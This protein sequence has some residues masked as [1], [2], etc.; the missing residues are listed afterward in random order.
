MGG[1][2]SGERVRDE[3]EVSS[4]KRSKLTFPRA[5]FRPS[6]LQAHTQTTTQSHTRIYTPLMLRTASTPRWPPSRS[7]CVRSL[8]RTIVRE[9]ALSTEPAQ[10]EPTSSSSA[11][12]CMRSS[13]PYE[14][15]TS[16]CTDTITLLWYAAL[17]TRSVFAQRPGT[18][19]ANKVSSTSSSSPSSPSIQASSSSTSPTRQPPIRTEPEP[20][21]PAMAAWT[22]FGQWS[23]LEPDHSARASVTVVLTTCLS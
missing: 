4:T 5:G 11:G 8:G 7:L 13:S 19:Q 22:T 14:S 20:I 17:V 23:D 10:P 9:R 3:R 12:Q 16:K 6:G 15:Q 18:N 1:C 2:G 21:S